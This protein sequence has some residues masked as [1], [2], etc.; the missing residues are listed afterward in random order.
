MPL[1]LQVVSYAKF[2]YPTNALVALK[3]D[4]HGPPPQPRPS[5]SRALPG[6]RH[7]P[8]TAKS[9]PT[10]TELG[11]LLSPGRETGWPCQP[12]REPQLAAEQWVSFEPTVLSPDRDELGV[13]GRGTAQGKK[14]LTVGQT[15]RRAVGRSHAH[16]WV[17][18]VWLSAL[19]S[20]VSTR[21]LRTL[22][23]SP[24]PPVTPSAPTAPWALA[25]SAQAWVGRS[26]GPTLRARGI[27]G[28]PSACRERRGGRPGVQPQPPG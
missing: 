2:L 6:S 12:S 11:A 1:P 4:S 24:H 16:A 8:A 22:G 20:F 18:R 26:Q 13:W 9:A 19:V 25:G 7:K 3:T 5:V 27:S 21:G 15:P 23:A 17:G 28:L 10:G 14:G